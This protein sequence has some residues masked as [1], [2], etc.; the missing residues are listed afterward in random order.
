[1]FGI[2]YGSH[3]AKVAVFDR[4]TARP[5][6]LLNTE[7]GNVPYWHTAVAYDKSQRKLVSGSAAKAIV[8]TFYLGQLSNRFRPSRDASAELFAPSRR[9]RDRFTSYTDLNHS[10]VPSH[11]A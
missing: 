6:V 7:D 4:A 8:R 5:K 9:R 11:L 10:L 1:M 3:L 2:D